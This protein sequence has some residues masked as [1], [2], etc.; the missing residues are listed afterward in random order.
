VS[1]LNGVFEQLSRIGSHGLVWLAIG[2]VLGLV[3]RRPAVFLRVAIADALAELVSGLL[4]A[5]IPRARPHDHP[6]VAVPHSH[7][8]PSGHATV[9]FACAT[10]LAAASPA[11]RVPFYVLAAA[12]AWSRVYNGVHWPLDV[13][14][15]AALGIAVGLFVRALRLPGES[16]RGSPR[17]WRTG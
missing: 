9:S 11:L 1:W 12:I 2:L 4:K 8:F 5:A 16:R 10:V 14:A 13:L 6:L 3:Q 7:S 17:G 15:G